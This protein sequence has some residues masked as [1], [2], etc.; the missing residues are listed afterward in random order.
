M[1]EEF[2]GILRSLKPAPKLFYMAL[3]IFDQ[4]WKERNDQ[5]KG[6][7]TELKKQ[8]SLIDRKVEHL[9]D[10][11]VDADSADL[12]DVYEDKIRSLKGEKV[13]ISEKVKNC[14]RPLESFEDSFR[15]AMTFFGNPQKL[16]DSGD[17]EQRRMLLRMAFSDRITY[18]RNQGFRTASIAQPFKLLEHL[19]TGEN[20]MVVY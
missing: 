16:W 6:R 4:L 19:K 5:S 11:V 15:T 9:L 13:V 2:L 8:L 14:G 7:A 17:I 1:E 18:D 12:I 3:D 10:R 20:A